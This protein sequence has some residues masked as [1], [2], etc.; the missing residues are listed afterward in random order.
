MGFRKKKILIT[1]DDRI[2]LMQMCLLMR[3]MGLSV[4]PAEDGSEVLKLVKLQR[5]DLIMLDIHMSMIDGV[6]TLRYLVDDKETSE[7][8]VVIVSSDRNLEIV[9][10]CRVLGAYAFLKKPVDIRNL[11]ETLQDCLFMGARRNRKYLRSPYSGYVT[12]KADG[13]QQRYAAETIS[14]RGIY[15][16][17]PEPLPVGSGVEIEIDLDD[18]KPVS[19][20]GGVIY[21]KGMFG[22]GFDSPPG[23]AIEFLDKDQAK[24]ERLTGFVS[25]ILTREIANYGRDSIV[26]S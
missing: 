12:L 23:M 20:E 26:I 25:G 17:S 8:P 16:I 21:H 14:E 4:I 18:G 9:E 15:L 10:Q 22:G 11:H 19:L 3:K 24:L 1:D 13:T 6:K 5:P 2:F 7:I